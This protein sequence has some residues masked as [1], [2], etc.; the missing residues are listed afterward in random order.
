MQ[1]KVAEWSPAAWRYKQWGGLYHDADSTH[2]LYVNIGAG[3]VGFPAR[4]GATPEITLLTLKPT[5]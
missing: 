2:A 5:H 3:T 4:I 1:I